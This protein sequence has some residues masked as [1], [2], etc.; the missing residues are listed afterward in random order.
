MKIETYSFPKSSF[1]SVEKDMEIFVNHFL[2]NERLKKLL[3]YDTPDALKQPEVP[4]DKALGMFGKQIKIVPK[5]KVDQ[6][7]FCYVIISFDNF[8]QN[9]TNPEFRDNI[10]SFDI[11]CHFDQWSLGNFALRPYKIAAEI[12][13]MF[14]RKKLTGIGEIEFLGANQIILSDEFAGLT[15][16]YQTIHGYDG[17][18]SKH[19]MNPK[20][21][22]DINSNW[23]KV[24]NQ[25][26]GL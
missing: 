5:L 6:P 22:A 21:Q 4:R 23:D 16:M 1:L 15:L 7:E 17:E 25:K 12:D 13:S 11:I 2:K 18:D 3:Y 10:I 26:N 8:T 20:E 24:F 19:A 14:N 9:M